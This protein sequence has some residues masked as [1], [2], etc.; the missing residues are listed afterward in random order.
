MVN[1]GIVASISNTPG[2]KLPLPAVDRL[3]YEDKMNAFHVFDSQAVENLEK[4]SLAF[5]HSP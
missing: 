2:Q 3:K 1:Q 5:V 4:S